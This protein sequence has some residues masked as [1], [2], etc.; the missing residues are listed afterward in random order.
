MAHL[1]TIHFLLLYSQRVLPMWAQAFPAPSFCLLGTPSSSPTYNSQE[2]HRSSPVTSHPSGR[3]PIHTHVELC[4]CIVP[5][6][7]GKPF[8]FH[9]WYHHIN[10]NSWQFTGRHR[11]P[12]GTFCSVVQKCPAAKKRAAI[13]VWK[14]LNSSCLILTVITSCY[15]RRLA[16]SV[17]RTS[18]CLCRAVC[19][20]AR[21]CLSACEWYRV[22]PCM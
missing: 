3:G 6:R 15:G 9:K 16:A 1:Q 2:C 14:Q 12:I 17:N 18:R 8:L 21:K 19:L 22:P 4:S 10:N 11:F 20:P 7:K 13:W 5:V